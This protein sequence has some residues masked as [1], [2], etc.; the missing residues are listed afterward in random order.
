MS[1]GPTGF[2]GLS[3]LGVI[4]SIGWASLGSRVVAVDLDHDPVERLARGELPLH[5]PSLPELF[6]TTR[7]RMC[8][9]ADPA[10][11]GECDLVIVSRDIPTDA[12]NASDCSVVD[13]LIDAAIPH[14]RPGSTLV[15]M[16]QVPPG[17]TRALATKIQARRP[18]AGIAVYY[19]V[20]T[21]VLGNAVERFLKP[22]RLIVGAAD[23][24]RPL[25]A[26]LDEGLRRFGCP[27]L[28]MGYES[29]ELTK[30]AINLYL[31]GAVT[32]ANT[33]SDLCEAVGAN[34]S[35]M[36][37]A[38][39]LDR[40]IGPS[41][42][43]RPSL[44]VAGGNL[45]RDLVTLRG[46]GQRHGVDVAYV[47]TLLAHNARR[48]RWVHRQL[49]RRVLDRDSR[50]VVAVWGLAYKK[51]TRSTKNSMALRVIENLRGR[52]EVRAY[53]PLVKGRDVDVA[54]T[55][56]ESRDAALVGAD[57]L[58]ILT[59]C[60]EFAAPAG[61]GFKTMRRPVVIDCVGVM[62]AGRADLH[63]VEYVAMG[64]PGRR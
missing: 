62:D 32:Y 30:T 44:G 50:P 20:E 58:L 61:A 7:V 14:L 22:E 26:D 8:F 41:A 4:S 18:E 17:S 55:L 10:A 19:W 33:L 1:G 11:L 36:V 24:A 49:E 38:L 48:Y 40:R 27:I 52:A 54:A 12:D 15:L 63:G 37:P 21:L 59:D 46:L 2:L 5:E 64:R 25:P 53:D 43:I 60:D 29:A 28:P 9:S 57:C 34:W 35:E 3:H 39:R 45:E 6:A 51:D 42:Y 16:S 47:D 56:V 13:R 31:F 23:P